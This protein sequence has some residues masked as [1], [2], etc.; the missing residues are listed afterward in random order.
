[1]G[2]VCQSH[3]VHFLLFLEISFAKYLYVLL[4]SLNNVV[5]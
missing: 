2:G 5:K 3:W 4:M 1:M